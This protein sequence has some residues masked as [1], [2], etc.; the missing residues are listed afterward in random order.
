MY[1]SLFLIY[2][3]VICCIEKY[4][5]IYFT[6][7]QHICVLSFMK[8]HQIDNVPKQTDIFFQTYLVLGIPRTI[9]NP[10]VFVLLG[11]LGVRQNVAYWFMW[12]HWFY[13]REWLWPIAMDGPLCLLT[14][15]VQVVNTLTSRDKITVH[16]LSMGYCCCIPW[17]IC[18]LDASNKVNELI[19][20]VSSLF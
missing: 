6:I 20:F 9:I 17:G 7:S 15:G 1:I 10:M 2:M 13:P 4:A 19:T 16:V 5:Y 8:H 3:K 12:A 11:A 18:N 14:L